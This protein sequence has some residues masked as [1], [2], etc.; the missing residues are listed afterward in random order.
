MSIFIMFIF[1]TLLLFI[2]L[3]FLFTLWLRL[4]VIVTTNFT[5]SVQLHKVFILH[6]AKINIIE[7]LSTHHKT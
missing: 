2:T 6:T 3:L 4:P 5:T 1:I 7:N